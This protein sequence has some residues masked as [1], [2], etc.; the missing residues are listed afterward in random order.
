MCKVLRDASLE[1]SCKPRFVPCCCLGSTDS[2]KLGSN[3]MGSIHG[4]TCYTDIDARKKEFPAAFV[5]FKSRYGAHMAAQTMQT[6]NPMVWVTETAPEPHD[7]HW[8]HIRVPYRQIWIRKMATFAASVAFMLV[9]LIP[10]TF[11][12]GL[13]QLEKLQ[14]MF[15]FLTGVLTK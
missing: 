5:F 8:S 10:V 2:F 4:K 12:Q 15:P 7:V 13:T 14:K 9:F 3:E 1:K 11:V 6:S